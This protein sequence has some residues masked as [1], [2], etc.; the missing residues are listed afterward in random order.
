[1]VKFELDEKEMI[2]IEDVPSYIGSN[3]D[4]YI[5]LPTQIQR[6]SFLDR[7]VTYEAKQVI[8]FIQGAIEENHK[9]YPINLNVLN[10]VKDRLEILRDEHFG[11]IE[12]EIQTTDSHFVRVRYTK[13][14]EETIEALSYYHFL[15]NWANFKDALI[16]Y[17]QVV[18]FF[19][20]NGL[21][22]IHITLFDYFL[23]VCDMSGEL[24]RTAAKSKRLAPIISD[25][26]R[27]LYSASDYLCF[28]LRFYGNDRILKSFSNKLNEM[29]RSLRKVEKNSREI[30]ATSGTSDI[31][32]KRSVS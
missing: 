12:K 21:C 6:I 18:E 29:M 25:F 19:N 8:T 27:G 22:H 13:C 20:S 1:M 23:G 28:A 30:K 17:D 11:A 24:M 14:V 2:S 7:S 26:I 3:L 4:T 32:L 5:R 9:P 31:P 16:T 10:K 15:C